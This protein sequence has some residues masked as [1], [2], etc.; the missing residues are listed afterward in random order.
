MPF[1]EIDLDEAIEK[2]RAT[3]PAF[4]EAWDKAHQS[5][6]K[7]FKDTMTGL[8]EAVAIEKA[9][10]KNNTFEDFLRELYTE[11]EIKRLHRSA[12]K[13]YRR[14]KRRWHKL[15][16]KRRQLSKKLHLRFTEM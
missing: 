5:E 10:P 15:N 13:M 9:P 12:H 2:Q 7:F 11:E 3:D 16:K 14:D 4:R 1:K 8:C 6:N